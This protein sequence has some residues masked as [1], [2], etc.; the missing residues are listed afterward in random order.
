MKKKNLL[1]KLLAVSLI[2]T[3]SMTGLFACSGPT[4]SAGNNVQPSITMPGQTLEVSRYSTTFN[5]EA[6]TI[7]I[8][9]NATVYPLTLN[10]ALKWTF[11]SAT[12]GVFDNGT[13][14]NDVAEIIPSGSS[15]VVKVKR[16]FLGGTITVKCETTDLF[17]NVSGVTKIEYQGLPTEFSATYNGQASSLENPIE[18]GANKEISIDFNFSNFFNVLGPEYSLDSCDYGVKVFGTMRLKATIDITTLGKTLVNNLEYTFDDNQV[19]TNLSSFSQGT[20][21]KAYFQLKNDGTFTDEELEYYSLSE[22]FKDLSESSRYYFDASLFIADGFGNISLSAD[23]N[24]LTG[25]SFMSESEFSSFRSG[26]L[27]RFASAIDADIDGDLEG[28]VT[29]EYDFSDVTFYIGAEKNVNG[30]LISAGSYFKVVPTATGL[31]IAGG[32]VVI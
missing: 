24:T 12:G 20:T 1:K 28:Y 6:N 32:N 15:A 14:V 11:E 7:D 5:Q 30:T 16:A 17:N 19:F 3:V 25:V 31:E 13:S 8:E 27:Q 29:L 2:G 21:A 4:A 23:S 10:P 26:D 22:L 9:L 18:I